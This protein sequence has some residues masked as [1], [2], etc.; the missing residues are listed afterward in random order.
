M[1]Y[2]GV[3][4]QWPYTSYNGYSYSNTNYDNRQMYSNEAYNFN[5]SSY[6]SNAEATFP[7]NNSTYS[8]SSREGSFD[9]NYN[10]E[11]REAFEQRPVDSTPQLQDKAFSYLY[12]RHFNANGY[13]N[14][15]GYYN[16]FDY[17]SSST[18][19]TASKNDVSEPADNKYFP[20]CALQYYETD[21]DSIEED[22]FTQQRNS[23]A[24]AKT[25]T[26]TASKCNSNDK[27]MIICYAPIHALI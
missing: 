6:Q 25:I 16:D 22:D 20:P 13:D 2:S 10:R 9:S 12:G 4:D 11:Q 14:S 8:N 27:G 21:V 23:C 17:K 3:H 5:D 7:Y 1:Y 15:Q 18:G 26:R 24:Y 19:L